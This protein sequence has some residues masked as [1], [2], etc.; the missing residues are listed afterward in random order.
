MFNIK[1]DIRHEFFESDEIPVVLLREFHI[2][3]YERIVFKNC[4]FAL[5]NEGVDK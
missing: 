5:R 3:E 1:G 2:L 4:V